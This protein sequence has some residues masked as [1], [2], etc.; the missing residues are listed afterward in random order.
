MKEGNKGRN[1][2]RQGQN[3]FNGYHATG[4]RRTD[5]LH[6]EPS[7]PHAWNLRLE[8]VSHPAHV[9]D[10]VTILTQGL[11]KV[12]DGRLQPL[13]IAREGIAP[14]VFLEL[15][16]RDD[17]TRALKQIYQQTILCLGQVQRATM[18]H[19]RPLLMVHNK[20]TGMHQ[21]GDLL[22]VHKIPKG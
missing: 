15:G 6:R 12:L 9:S 3:P 14:N 19:D 2:A 22:A 13:R 18:Q 17:L 21:A 1:E 16:I 5:P 11:A 8:L 4:G 7:H 10:G 20:R